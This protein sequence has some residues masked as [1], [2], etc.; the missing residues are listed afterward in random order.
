MK[1]STKSRYGLRALVDLAAH[2]TGEQVPLTVIAKR[3]A[4][5]S[6][7]LEQVFALLKRAGIVKSIKGAQGGYVLNKLPEAITVADVIHAIE[8][9]VLIV[10]EQDVEEAETI[11]C[12][13]MQICLQKQIWDKMQQ[14]VEEVANSI[15]LAHLLEEYRMRCNNKETMYYI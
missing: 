1:I 13:N 9:E 12:K 3:Q 15:T 6:N 5:S 4:L 10:E 8:G 7:Y 2:S 11:A 14:S